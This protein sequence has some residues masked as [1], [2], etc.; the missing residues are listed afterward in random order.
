[1]ST[2]VVR[3]TK[4]GAIAPAQWIRQRDFQRVCEG[5]CESA[6]VRIPPRRGKLRGLLYDLC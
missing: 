3:V 6:C 2:V 1:M 5:A 4:G